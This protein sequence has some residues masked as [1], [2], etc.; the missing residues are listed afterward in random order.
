M[1]GTEPHVT[2]APVLGQHNDYVFGE[3]LGMSKE[4]IERLVKE[5][6]IY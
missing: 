4:E 3:L 2:A 6:I 1:D 5:Q